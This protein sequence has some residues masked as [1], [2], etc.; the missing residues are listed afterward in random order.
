MSKAQVQSIDGDESHAVALAPVAMAM[1]PMDVISRAV[2]EGRDVT[3]IE[4]LMDLQERWEKNQ[5]KKAFDDAMASAKAE[6]PP[7]IKNR[8]VGFESRKAG[9][10]RTDYR[11]EDLAE[12]A[13][14]VDP[15]LSKFGL[16]YR[17][18]TS[19]PVNEPVTVTCVVSHR[20][21]YS[22]ENMLSAGRDD[23]GN[24]NSIQQVGST[25]TYLQRYTLK[26]ALGLAASNDDDGRAAGT[27]DG[28]ISDKQTDE[29]AA[30]ITETKSDIARFLTWAAAPS[31]SDIKTSQFN[32][33]VAMLKAKQQR[34]ATK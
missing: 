11:H 25:I 30:L 33:C 9:A 17:F 20:L 15:I 7:I 13:R 10:A 31:I 18:R 3:V 29:I 22:E 24:K 12:I 32:D 26:A 34:G 2:S 16:S 14:T 8:H 27:N 28:P 1:T 23:S 4:K 5:A 21:G 19:S 6:I